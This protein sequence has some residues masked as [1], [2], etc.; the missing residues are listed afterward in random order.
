MS[1]NVV[2]PPT[3]SVPVSMIMLHPSFPVSEFFFTACSSAWLD[4][5]LLLSCVSPPCVHSTPLFPAMIR[6]PCSHTICGHHPRCSFPPSGLFPFPWLCVTSP[7][8]PQ[9]PITPYHVSTAYVFL[10]PACPHSPS[11]RLFFLCQTESSRGQGEG[12]GDALHC[13]DSL[14]AFF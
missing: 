7:F 10:Y 13:S 9:F 12:A 1:T 3:S 6:S 2:R 14:S 4:A 8:H 11:S 5:F